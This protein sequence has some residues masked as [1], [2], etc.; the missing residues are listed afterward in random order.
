MCFCMNE[1]AVPW[2]YRLVAYQQGYHPFVV[3]S[4]N[5]YNMWSMNQLMIQMRQKKEMIHTCGLSLASLP[6]PSTISNKPR[7]PNSVMKYLCTYHYR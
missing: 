1:G 3:P 4:S 6:L 7:K 5:Q 2:Q